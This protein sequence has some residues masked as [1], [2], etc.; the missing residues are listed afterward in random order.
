V[1]WLADKTEL[2][3]GQD[4]AAWKAL[5]EDEKRKRVSDLLTGWYGDEAKKIDV[6]LTRESPKNPSWVKLTFQNIWEKFNFESK[7]KKHRDEQTPLG[8]K[9]FYSSR[10]TPMEF[11]QTKKRLMEAASS[12][13][14]TDWYNH[15]LSS[16][17]DLL[18]KVDREAVKKSAYVRVKTKFVPRFS[19]LVE[20]L[21]PWHK[22]L[23]RALD[24]DSTVNH[25]PKYDLFNPTPCPNTLQ[26]PSLTKHMQL[27]GMPQKTRELTSG[28]PREPHPT[29]SLLQ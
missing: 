20:V 6:F 9:T 23:W 11:Y 24:F 8:N 17:A 4:P 28:Y 13:V 10:L 3:D 26:S 16:K 19:A 15:V 12:K 22:S 21:D 25:F 14:A 5:S 7:L 2:L 18:W 1:Y 29:G 27:G